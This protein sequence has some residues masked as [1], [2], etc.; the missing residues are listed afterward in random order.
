MAVVTANKVIIANITPIELNN[1]LSIFSKPFFCCEYVALTM[2]MK[3]ETV[4]MRGTNELA[5]VDEGMVVAG[6]SEPVPLPSGTALCV[7]SR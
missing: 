4:N 7:E 3:F 1:F 5:N 6:L 2:S